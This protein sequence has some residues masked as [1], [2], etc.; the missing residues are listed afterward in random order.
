MCVLLCVCTDDCIV[1]HYCVQS[2]TVILEVLFQFYMYVAKMT[3]KVFLLL[4]TE[5][6]I[7]L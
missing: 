7:N 1:L 5:F 3:I 2:R 4:N 6:I